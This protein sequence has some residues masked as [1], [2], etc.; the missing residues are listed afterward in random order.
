M[1]QDEKHVL[2]VYLVTEYKH[3]RNKSYF[4][5]MNYAATCIT[6][7]NPVSTSDR[8]T[9]FEVAVCL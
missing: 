2:Y 5:C 7:H 8:C 9:C 3:K 4:P 6:A 1:I